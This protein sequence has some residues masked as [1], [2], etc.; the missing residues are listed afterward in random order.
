MKRLVGASVAR[1]EVTP[2]QKLFVQMCREHAQLRALSVAKKCPEVAQQ[3]LR[4]A[5]AQ[6]LK[7]VDCPGSRLAYRPK[8]VAHKGSELARGTSER[9]VTPV[10][11]CSAHYTSKRKGHELHGTYTETE[12]CCF[13]LSP[14]N[15]R[16]P[17]PPPPCSPTLRNGHV[18]AYHASHAYVSDLHAE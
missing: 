17:S 9:Y 16:A 8:Q 2:Q 15:C 10:L 18:V 13:S 6:L 1:F 5:F 7:Q 14:Y 12:G 3:S 4:H 11:I